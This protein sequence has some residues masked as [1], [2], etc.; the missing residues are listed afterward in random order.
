MDKY[1]SEEYPKIDME[2]RIDRK[3]DES[4][5][6]PKIHSE[7]VKTLYSLKQATGKPMTVLL[8]QA[9]RDLA[10]NYGVVY[11][12]EKDPVL[13]NVEP[14]TWEDVCEYRKF[15]DELDYQKC[16]DEVQKI[17]NDVT[18]TQK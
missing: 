17:K 16:V 9:I 8:D 12:V 3:D 13:V 6:Q 2:N 18:P 7:R 1:I 15:L 10:E 4:L 14:E 5:Y 11:Q